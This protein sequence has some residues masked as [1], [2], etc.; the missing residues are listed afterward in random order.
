MLRD[1]AEVY[2]YRSVH[3]NF[4]G[5]SGH[6]QKALKLLETIQNPHFSTVVTEM[7]VNLQPC[8]QRMDATKGEALPKICTCGT[9]DK[10]LGTALQ[11]MHALEALR[12]DC[13]LCMN[14][15]TGRHHYLGE[16][17]TRKLRELRYDCRC[18]MGNGFDTATVF[19][20]PWMQ[21]IT[22][23][24]WVPNLWT[25]IPE[26]KLR[27]LMKDSKFLPNVETLQYGGP[28][29]SEELLT[30][31]TIR[32]LSSPFKD[33]SASINQHPNK[34]AIT[35]LSIGQYH[36]KTLLTSVGNINQFCNLQHIGTLHFSHGYNDTS[37]TTVSFVVARYHATMLT[38]HS[39]K[40]STAL[41]NL[42]LISRN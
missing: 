10:K 5:T 22:A 33:P 20:A 17:G 24:N 41:W 8:R 7:R 12:I 16:L 9:I 26:V 42:S 31:R 34:K 38:T 32:R 1:I 28:G 25:S 36:L 29:I 14:L 11:S 40:L 23:L 4:E 18:S 15:S 30:K 19:S 35:H 37:E 27:E 2:L 13:F 39:A 3:L 6:A 21:S